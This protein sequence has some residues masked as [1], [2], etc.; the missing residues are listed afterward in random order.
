VPE[1]YRDVDRW[2]LLDTNLDLPRPWT[3]KTNI[4][5]FSLALVRGER[6]TRRWLVYVHSPLEDQQSVMITVPGF[7]NITVDVPRAGVFYLVEES[8][9][10]VGPIDSIIPSILN[11]NRASGIQNRDSR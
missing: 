6:G 3:Q 2:F 4:P 11:E 9:K 5:V 8:N 10:K 7:G 1:K